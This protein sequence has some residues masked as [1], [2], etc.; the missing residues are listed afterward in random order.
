[1]NGLI[2]EAAGKQ[3]FPAI[4]ARIGQIQRCLDAVTEKVLK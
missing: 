1:M 2:G 4:N 3:R